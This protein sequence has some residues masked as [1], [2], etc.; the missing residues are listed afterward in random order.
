M[1]ARVFSSLTS[2]GYNMVTI[3]YFIALDFH[4]KE[5]QYL[6]GEK[7]LRHCSRQKPTLLHQEWAFTRIPTD[8]PHIFPEFLEN[9]ETRIPETMESLGPWLI[10]PSFP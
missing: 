7:H 4:R 1:P 9:W 8:L 6:M 5:Q 2:L 3:L 10:G